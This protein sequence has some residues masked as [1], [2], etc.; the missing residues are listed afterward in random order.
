[1]PSWYRPDAEAEELI[2]HMLRHGT[3]L[4]S[5]LIH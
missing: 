5:C 3:C 1:M 4:T 2:P